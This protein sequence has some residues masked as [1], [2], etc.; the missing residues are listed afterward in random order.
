MG[1]PLQ[2][3]LAALSGCGYF[4]GFVGFDIWPLIFVFLVPVCWAIR[5]VSP[6]RAILLGAVAG[7]VANFGGY[8]WVIH[9]LREFADLSLP[10]AV[11]GWVLL[12]AYQG[13]LV[14]VFIGLTRWFQVHL[15]WPVILSLC[16]TFPFAETY[17]PLLFPSYVGNAL[18]LVPV[19]TQVVELFGM[20]GLTVLIA[21]VNGII[22][23][24][25][26]AR[27]QGGAWPRR[28]ILPALG[29]VVFV[30][31]FGV[32]RLPQIDARTQGAPTAKVGLVQA[33]LGARDKAEKSSEFIRR[34]Q[35][36]TRELLATRPDLDL[37]VWPESA[38][39]RYIRRDTKNLTKDVVPG[40]HVPVILGALTYERGQG[41]RRNVYNTA[42]A[43]SSTGD[44]LGM[45][46]KIEL[47]AFGETLPFWDTFPQLQ[48]W[49]PRSSFFTRGTNLEHFH[50]PEVGAL[51]PMICYEDIIPTLV[52]RIWRA[53]G[54]PTVLVNI[55][56]DSW[57]GD[58]HEPLIHLV[59]ASFRS[60]ETRRA[61][62]RSTNTGISAF[63]DPAGR[64]V[65]RTGQW[66]QETLVA[67]VPI[68]EDGLTPLYQH[69]GDALGRLGLFYVA[70]GTLRI[71]R[72]RRSAS[73]P[74]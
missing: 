48:S 43:T 40:I 25:L 46:D 29:Y 17:Y 66:T 15:G 12:C 62:I 67:E 64:I 10:L 42:V 74:A 73:R 38:Y 24:L 63:V 27:R 71:L 57:Y 13:F 14:G 47:L 37:V 18:Y 33:N 44:V 41:D 4:L 1:L 21:A 31:G 2:L 30:I 55:T 36:M 50:I 53:S 20:L 61:L 39:N 9:L 35:Q 22:Y 70:V 3:L 59:L 5:D 60:I 51:L 23:E 11:L 49:F 56:N 45:F 52:R 8:Y 34:H 69:L 6:R 54:P 72:Q 26:A 7:L 28:R 16:L 32:V 68:F 65:A 19:L 58:T